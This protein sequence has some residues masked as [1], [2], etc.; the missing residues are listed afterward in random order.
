MI[1]S[2]AFALLVLCGLPAAASAAAAEL[3]QAAAQTL[4]DLA[5]YRKIV[6]DTLVLVNAND[7]PGAA[8]RITDLET[9]W[10]AAETRMKPRNPAKWTSLDNVID[11]TL[12]VLRA[13]KPAAAD[14]IKALELLLAA[15]D[16]LAGA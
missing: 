5:P 7:L 6:A 11:H 10:D 3:A 2:F 12:S 8:K 14:G 4:G 16:T 9:A 13:R 1:R 15:I